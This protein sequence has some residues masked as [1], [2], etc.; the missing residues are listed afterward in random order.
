MQASKGDNDGAAAKEEAGDASSHEVSGPAIDNLSRMCLE[1]ITAGIAPVDLHMLPHQTLVQIAQM[2]IDDIASMKR[3]RE[4]EQHYL[5]E[6]LALMDRVDETV[7]ARA[8]AVMQKWQRIS[9]D[10]LPAGAQC[11]GMPLDIYW[12]KKTGKAEI[13]EWIDR[14][15]DHVIHGFVL[16]SALMLYRLQCISGTACVHIQG[17]GYKCVW[18]VYM[19]HKAT[20]RVMWFHDYKGTFYCR[21]QRG[22]KPEQYQAD[23]LE[24]INLLFA[25]NCPHPYDGI[26]AGT[27]A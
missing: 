9:K 7:T 27:V 18:E 22:P 12:N 11:E 26:I 17:E 20:N 5:V 23:G 14:S 1:Q 21:F 6:P 3:A 16:S 10:E 19:L 13:T 25:P 4:N 8:E 24:L 2:S 15:D